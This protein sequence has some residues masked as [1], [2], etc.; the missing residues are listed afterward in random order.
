MARRSRGQGEAGAGRTGGSVN[1]TPVRNF[2][3][4]GKT[5]M[6]DL[7]DAL[8]DEW[9]R[10]NSLYWIMPKEGG[11][12]PFVMNEVQ[13]RFYVERHVKNVILKARQFGFTTL[14]CLM[15]LDK[16]LF[17]PNVRCGIIA[18]N[19]ED[20]E[21]FFRDKIKFAYERLPGWFK[22]FRPLVK[23]SGKEL[24]VSH[25]KWGESSV[26]VGT[27]L[28]GG[29]LQA[30][31]LS[32]FGRICEKEPEKAKEIKRAAL[33]TVAAGQ[34]VYVES[35]GRGGESDFK[36]MCDQWRARGLDRRPLGPM[37]YKFHF[38]PWFEH[39]DYEVDP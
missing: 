26:R 17:A 16:V 39:S 24:V 31:H 19:V 7:L 33:N 37:E 11:E 27:T 15:L 25:G 38:Y 5:G 36:A 14:I 35:T 6:D 20:A 10:L 22:E 8:G 2:Y 9:I 34:E 3:N 13:R 28:L 12:V 18:H 4:S 1:R 23:D 29:T 32:E 21:V 30:L